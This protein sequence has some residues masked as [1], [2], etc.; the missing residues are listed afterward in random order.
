[1]K[2]EKKTKNPSAFPDP[3]DR[4]IESQQKELKELRK[5][6]S[7]VWEIICGTESRHSYRAYQKDS[8][9]SKSLLPPLNRLKRECKKYL[10]ST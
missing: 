6:K 2:E 9:L 1:M 8:N 5:E 4:M 7:K 10:I 3:R